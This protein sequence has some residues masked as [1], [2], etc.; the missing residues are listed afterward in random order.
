[1]LI[2]FGRLVGRVFVLCLP[3][4]AGG[5]ADSSAAQDRLE[6]LNDIWAAQRSAVWTARIRGRAMRPGHFR[7]LSPEELREVL[8]AVDVIEDQDRL[9]EL[10]VP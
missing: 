9:V 4:L 7:P 6:Y 10:M 1:M 2:S 3:C 8:S 5:Q